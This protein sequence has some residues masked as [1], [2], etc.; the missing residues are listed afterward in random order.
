MKKILTLTIIIIMI[1]MSYK[2]SAQQTL[3][4]PTI[5]SEI[6][7]KTH[8][9]N[10]VPVPYQHLRQADVMWSKTI[11]RV[12]DLREKINLQYYYPEIPIPPRF[13]LIDVVLTAIREGDLKAYGAI[14]GQA[15]EFKDI[16]ESAEIETLMGG[17]Q[18]T[19]TQPDE[20]GNPVQVV[21]QNEVIS[22]N[23]KEYII[24]ELWFF[25]KQRS[26]L[27]PRIIGMCPIFHFQKDPMDP[28]SWTKKMLFWI[29]FDEARTTFVKNEVFS[30]A[31]NDAERLTF[32]DMFIKRVFSSYIIR[33]SNMYNNRDISE[34]TV[35]VGA[36]LESD[37]IK[38]RVFDFE[39]TLWEY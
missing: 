8:V 4:A 9:E 11:W 23:V 21:I 7:L 12:I 36:L 14:P 2:T 26:V 17:G 5:D 37:N 20:N 24:K 32:D 15:N 19:V 1:A 16:I 35:G 33:E 29:S 27:E 22:Y 38:G 18:D 3:D 25:D 10:R 39:Q 6:Y 34:Y 28:D 30:L 13:S 31:G